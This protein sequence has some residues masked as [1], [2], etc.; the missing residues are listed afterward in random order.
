MCS[1]AVLLFPIIPVP[2]ILVLVVL[3][4]GPPAFNALLFDPC[5]SLREP[6]FLFLSFYIYED[7][8]LIRSRLFL[9]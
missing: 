6:G 2:V 5:F 8:R 3:L 4:K 1:T 7:L 9:F